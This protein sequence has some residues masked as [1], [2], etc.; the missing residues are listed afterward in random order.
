MVRERVREGTCGMEWDEERRREEGGGR[1][2]G[3]TS[4][5]R[6][7]QWFEGFLS[8]LAGLAARGGGGE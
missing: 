4:E 6:P 3:G 8:W 7:R 5:R 1:N 2:D